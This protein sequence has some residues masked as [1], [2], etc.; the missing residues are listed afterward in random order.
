MTEKRQ[1]YFFL[2]HNNMIDHRIPVIYKWANTYDEEI[3]VVLTRDIDYQSDYRFDVLEQYPHVTI[4]ERDVFYR[5]SSS[6]QRIVRSIK[7]MSRQLPTDLPRRLYRAAGGQPGPSRSA[8]ETALETIVSSETAVLVFDWSLT[9]AAMA[10]IEANDGEHPIVSLPHGDTPYY[11]PIFSES[12]LQ[13]VLPEDADNSG[14]I[15]DGTNFNEKVYQREIISNFDN[16]SFDWHEHLFRYT[17]PEWSKH[18]VFDYVVAPNDITA[19][20]WRPFLS[21]E[22]I[23]SLGSPR[24]ND[25]WLEVLSQYTPSFSTSGNSEG[26]KKNRT[27]SSPRRFAPL[28]I[29][30]ITQ[31]RP[32]NTI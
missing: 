16:E 28:E 18:E 13:N 27:L 32:H 1:P 22:K 25:E 26:R 30:H 24:Y 31:H 12:I 15:I 21:N 10:L 19:K 3:R 14:T 29:S 2:A 5:G 6:Q 20:R 17:Q 11:N 23:K 9:P 8:A 4:H 7:D